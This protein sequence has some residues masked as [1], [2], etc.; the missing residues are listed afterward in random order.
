MLLNLQFNSFFCKTTT[1]TELSLH[2]VPRPGIYELQS[3]MSATLSEL[4]RKRGY[5][6][7]FFT[8]NSTK[9][10]VI[11]E[12]GKDDL[13]TDDLTS[14]DTMLRI[15]P[16]KLKEIIIINDQ[17]IQAANED[18]IDAE[19]EIIDE[20]DFE[21]RMLQL[22]LKK[23]VAKNSS[24]NP[25][26]NYDGTESVHSQTASNF[27]L[28]K[29]DLPKFDGKYQNWTPFLDFSTFSREQLIQMTRYPTFKSYIISKP[30]SEMSLQNFFHIFQLPAQTTK[31]Q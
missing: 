10:E 14:L 6:F 8:K 27:K 12:K 29:F 24:D 11:F 1:F 28:P 9:A 5:L 7:G 25:T 16:D 15:I 13:T 31:W 17:I 18:D 21:F 22:K 26:E 4:K 19:M 23:F 2:L 3:K 30:V 20:K